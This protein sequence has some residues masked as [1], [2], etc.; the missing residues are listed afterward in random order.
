[1]TVAAAAAKAGPYTGNDSAS[2]FD[3][4][5][6][7]FADTDIRV[8]AT[9]IAT[10]V[11]SD[12]VLN[13]DYTVARNADQDNDPGGTVT[14]KV[15][16]V[17]TAYPSTRKLTIVGDFAYEQPTD[18]PDG[19]S[20]F[21]TVIENALD[22]LTMLVKQAQEK[23]DRAVT[24]D[25]SGTTDPAALIDA[26]TTSSAAAVT[27]AAEAQNAQALAEAA[28][29]NLPNAVTAGANR[30]LKVNSAGTGWDYNLLH[31][32]N[33]GA[34]I[35]SAA[36][37]DLTAATGN[38]P[39]ITGTTPTSAVTMHTGQW[40][41]VV[42]DGAWPLTWH[43]TTNKLSTGTNYTCTAGDEILYYKDLSG[44]VHGIIFDPKG[45]TTVASSA[46][47]SLYGSPYQNITGTTSVSAFDGAAGKLY[48]C[49]AAGALPIQ[50]S[51]PTISIKQTGANITLDA[52]AT[53]DIYMLTTTT[54][55]VRN[56][57]LASGEPLT[58][59]SSSPNKLV[60][61]STG[62]GGTVT[63]STSKTTGVTLNKPCGK[64]IM[65]NAALAAGATVSFTLANSL[66][67]ATDVIALS[68]VSGTF[69]AS[70]TY[71]AWPDIASAGVI[72]INLKNNTA[73]SLS[74]AVGINFAIIKGVAA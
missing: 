45:A 69:A 64:I 12:L 60:G 5:F 68:F 25:V 70:G 40:E 46:T 57:Q 37:I 58:H 51:P 20:F 43:A 11:E 2:A 34:N 4:A 31:L 9:V 8:V 18:I 44:I 35:A 65:H 17:T 32:M 73:G 59:T 29:A 24:V 63:Q 23:L 62:S 10:G 74:E 49:V 55:E 1:M 15:G 67:S 66:V 26:L 39:R 54:C 19:G 16:G 22:R 52:G 6:K 36:T 71:M 42:A 61:Y 14:Y 21:A 41:L 48:H 38:S 72:T 27:A 13:T 53:F 50:H 33:A 28:A 47:V 30:F 3:F 7:V 56:I